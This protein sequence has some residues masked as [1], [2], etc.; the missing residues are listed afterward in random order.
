MKIIY[1]FKARQDLQNI[2]EYIAYTLLVPKTARIMYGGRD[3][4]N[5]LSET[6]EW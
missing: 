6:K 2:Y 5:Q 3:I 4:R 1:T